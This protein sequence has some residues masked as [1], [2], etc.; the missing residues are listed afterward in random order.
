[1]RTLTI[2]LLFASL[3][4]AGCK[5]VDCGKGTIERNG[6]C[7]P[8]DVV[9]GTAAC[10]ADTVLEGNQCVSTIV[11]D[12]A[13]TMA[14][15]DPQSGITTCVGTGTSPIPCGQPISCPAGSDSSKQTI[16]GQLYDLETGAPFADAGAGGAPCSGP[17]AAA[18]PCALQLTAYD[19]VQFGMNPMTAIPLTVGNAYVDTCGRFRLTDVSTPGGPY[20]GIGIDDASAGNMGPAGV[21]NAVGIAVPKFGGSA[22]K[23]VEGFIVKQSTTQAWE[24]S[25]GPALANG[26][27]VGLFRAHCTGAGCTGDAFAP[28]PG[29]SFTKSGTAI[30]SLDSYFVATDTMRTTIDPTATATGANGTGLLDMVSV[31]DGFVYSGTGGI[32]DTT[33]CRWQTA[34]AAALPNIVFVQVFR[35]QN[36]IGKTCTE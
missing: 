24:A 18:G 15:V 21:T 31:N 17:P 36:Q 23:D 33:D 2:T 30:P 34:A 6:T 10:G 16:C 7:A 1:M 25:G 20:I 11:C 13:T 19:A 22:T 12:P 8:A 3:A 32:T 5:N 27:Y 14:V 29:V 35:K 4:A 28:Q 26:I 9:T